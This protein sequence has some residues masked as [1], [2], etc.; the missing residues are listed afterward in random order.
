VWYWK[1]SFGQIVL[2]AVAP[3]L[4]TAQTPLKYRQAVDRLRAGDFAQGCDQVQ[5]AFQDAPGSY[6]VLNLLGLCATQKGDVTGAEA[7]FRRSIASNP[8]FPDARINLAVNLV[9]RSRRAE[10]IQQF[11]QALTIQPDNVTA[12]YNLGSIE[13]ESR[14]VRQAVMHLSRASTLAP[15]DA[16]ISL[17][18]SAALF[19]SSR[20]DEARVR[21]SRLVQDQTDPRVVFAAAILAARNSERSLARQGIEKAIAG[22]AGLRAEVV[23]LARAAFADQQYN[24]SEVL[25]SAAPAVRDAEW[26]AM[27]GY[28]NYKLGHPAEA[29]G[30]LQRALELDPNVEDYYMK[31]GELMLFHKSW[32]A[33]AT[34]FEAGLNRL[35]ESALLH[36]GLAVSS[37]AGNLDAEVTRQHLEIALRLKP[38]FKP[39]LSALAMTCE[40]SK[41]WDRLLN[42]AD[43]LIQSNPESHEGY[44]YKGLAIMKQ[45][46]G[47]NAARPWLEKA[48][49]LDSKFPKSR[50]VLGELLV[51]EGQLSMGIQQLERAIVLDPESTQAYY[52]LATAYKK[53][54][55]PQ[56]ATAAFEK[57]RELKAK[58]S[59]GW[60][61]LFQ[62]RDQPGNADAGPPPR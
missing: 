49:R 1:R 11:Q 2:L 12:L 10:A 4:G 32:R 62:L 60:L 29:Q 46:G 8:R 41:D 55:A 35:P 28:A 16:Q 14:S 57:F 6:F 45:G 21:I 54:G 56:K 43:R 47:L 40:Q 33:A 52:Q 23:R 58:Q 19:S 3:R 15:A 7:L 42:A 22:D 26:N 9:R 13:L 18:L 37:L 39:G 5:T 20:N 51:R 36:F 24:T 30:Y 59:T 48:T 25:L 38:D 61:E 44:Y 50:I 53:A 27:V 31:M 34:Y 17:A